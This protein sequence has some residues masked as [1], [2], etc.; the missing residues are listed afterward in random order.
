MQAPEG[1]QTMNKKIFFIALFFIIIYGNSF[2]E[3]DSVDKL[4]LDSD[5][6]WT[7]LTAFLV[8]FYASRICHGRIRFYPGQERRQHHDEKY[9][10]FFRRKPGILAHR[11][12][13]DVG[14][15]A[16]GFIGAPDIGLSNWLGGDDPNRF[17]YLIF[18]DRF[19]GHRR[20]HC[21]GRN[22]RKN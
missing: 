13:P 20:H 22:G 9:H 7:C 3:G 8:F 10:G 21:I 15:N 4:R 17:S 2:A 19:C 16:S 1:L 12:Q 5:I 18:S 6:L 14:A 11:H